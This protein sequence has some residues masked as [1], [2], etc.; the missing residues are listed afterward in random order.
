MI[1]KLTNKQVDSNKYILT[2]F[3]YKVV[4][5]TGYENRLTQNSL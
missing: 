1:G 2:N 5:Y 3:K 4:E